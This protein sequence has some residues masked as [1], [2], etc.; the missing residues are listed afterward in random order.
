MPKFYCQ[1]GAHRM[2]LDRPTRHDAA[3]RMME[4]VLRTEE[5]YG[6]LLGV[7][8]QGFMPDLPFH[9]MSPDDANTSARDSEGVYPSLGLLRELGL[10]PLM[11]EEEI[12]ER[13]GIDFDSMP[14]DGKAWLLGLE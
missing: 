4:A 9:A 12:A 13:C 11:T 14:E 3:L 10:E 1:T 7:S 8:E 6:L 5:P 2:I